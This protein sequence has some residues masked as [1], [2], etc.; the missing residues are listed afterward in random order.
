MVVLQTRLP[1]SGVGSQSDGF[2]AWMIKGSC[3]TRLLRT[4]ACWETAEIDTEP[5]HIPG[6]VLM[7]MG[8]PSPLYLN[9]LVIPQ[10]HAPFNHELDVYA[11]NTSPYSNGD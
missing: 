11:R 1:S 5:Y 9:I 6:D 10:W 7:A 4:Q 2:P 3:W 8:N